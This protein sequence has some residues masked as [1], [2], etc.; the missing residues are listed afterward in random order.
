MQNAVIWVLNSYV[1]I[2]NGIIIILSL[3]AVYLFFLDIFPRLNFTISQSEYLFPG[4]TDTTPPTMVGRTNHPPPD[5]RLPVCHYLRVSFIKMR[6]VCPGFLSLDPARH[7]LPSISCVRCCHASIVWLLSIW[8]RMMIMHR[9]RKLWPC[10]GLQ[11]LVTAHHR[12]KVTVIRVVGAGTGQP[13][14]GPRTSSQPSSDLRSHGSVGEISRIQAHR[15]IQLS[16]HTLTDNT[17]TWYSPDIE[18]CERSWTL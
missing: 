5:S 2:I 11:R 18:R 9:G 3:Q 14:L 15:V 6:G 8:Q 7:F 13:R 1:C 4:V 16:H 12:P 17:D 10:P